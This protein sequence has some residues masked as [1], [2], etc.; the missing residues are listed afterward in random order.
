MRTEIA[1]QNRTEPAGVATEEEAQDLHREEQTRPY[2]LPEEMRTE[3]WIALGLFAIAFLYLCL[4]RR[5]T[6][7]DPDEGIILQGAQR[8]LTGQVLYRD[9]FSFLTPGSYYW[10]ALLFRLFGS[11]MLVARTAV[12]VYGA[13]FTVFTYLVARRVCTRSGALLAAYLVMVTCL[14]WR[15]MWL[16][17]W[18]STLWACGAIYCAVRWLETVNNQKAESGRQK[19]A[20]GRK[21]GSAFRVS[22]FEFP[23]SSLVSRFSSLPLWA[24]GMGSCAALTFLFE[25]SKGTGLVLGLGLGFVILFL[26]DTRTFRMDNAWWVAIASG[27]A[28]PFLLTIAWFGAHHALPALW[29]DWLWPL[30]H[31]SRANAVSYGDQNWSDESRQAMFGSG[32]L[33][34]RLVAFV[35]VSP[36]L[37]LPV[38]PIVAIALLGYWT[39]A[40]KRGALMERRA[41]YYILICSTI[42][43]L[44]VSVIAV[45]AD[46]LHFVYLIPV[47]YLILSWLMDGTDIRAP[48]TNRIRPLLTVFVLLTFT[49]LAM[50]F[51]A[52]N[53]GGRCRLETRRGVLVAPRPDSVISY[54]QAH[55]PAG[56]KIFVYPY[57]PLYY[58]LT[59]TYS[60]GR[61]E[62][63]QPGMHTI[64]QVERAIREIHNDRTRVVLFEPGFNERIGPSWPNTPLR[65]IARDPVGDYILAH[66]HSCC[67]LKSAGGWR[68]LFMVSRDLPCP[69]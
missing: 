45:R 18:D 57:L 14:P 30:R 28:W 8:I 11:S 42:V 68:F 27:F 2:V 23:L 61:F 17:N 25:Q 13:I 48:L 33:I 51:L 59:A 19:A 35:A 24:F 49:T 29:T 6:L 67:I 47:L 12:A 63:L 69:S 15:F 38:L 52:R 64:E 60:P 10:L 58:Y 3:R 66:Y 4:F 26:L 7:L 53:N 41:G 9:F 36:S 1:D 43:G 55:V 22:K 20:R 54:T 44:L 46:S 65:S 34:Q 5:Y 56:S 40:A 32:P 50:A 37:L 39:L 21:L 31:Y 62:Y 16:H